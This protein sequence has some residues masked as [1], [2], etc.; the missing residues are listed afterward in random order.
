MSILSH[1]TA[2]RDWIS[3]QRQLYLL[4]KNQPELTRTF[5]A[6]TYRDARETL[7]GLQQVAERQAAMADFAKEF[8]RFSTML[9]ADG[10]AP[11]RKADAYPCLFD[12]TTQTEFDRH[13]IYHPAWAARVLAKLRPKKHVDI[14]SSLHFSTIVSAFVEVEFFDFRPAPVKLS[15]LSSSAADLTQLPFA[16]DSIESLSCMHVIE[17]I[18]LGRYGDPYDID[19]DTK[20]AR[21]LCRVLAPNGHLIV[22]FPVGR[23]RIQY[24]AHRV[25]SHE[26]VLEM[27][28][29]LRLTEYALIPDGRAEEGLIESPDCELIM[30]QRYGC[31]CYV[32]SK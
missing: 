16:S 29:G 10:R 17:H 3:I 32:F 18:G 19:G 31:G 2:F 8:D 14:S 22:A 5:L 28:S 21:E 24:N 23:S 7:A 12:R 26:Q 6:V 27:F 9:V 25:Y 20:A 13:Y 15:N 1:L 11:L 30:A 4:A